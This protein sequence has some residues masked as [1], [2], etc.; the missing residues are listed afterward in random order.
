[1]LL[2]DESPAAVQ[3]REGCFDD[4]GRG[5]FAAQVAAHLFAAARAVGEVVERAIYGLLLG[6]FVAELF[7]LFRR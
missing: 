6:L 2:H 3:A 5:F 1:M 7:E 4:V